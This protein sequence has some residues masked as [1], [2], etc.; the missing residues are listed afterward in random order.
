MSKKAYFWVKSAI[1][2][3]KNEVCDAAVNESMDS[4]LKPT[5]LDCPYYEDWKKSKMTM[6]EYSRIEGE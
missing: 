3:L 5:C 1:C 4:L 6:E 2:R